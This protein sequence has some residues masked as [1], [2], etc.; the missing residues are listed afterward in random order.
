MA[1][2][3]GA[4]AEARCAREGDSLG[5][6]SARPIDRGRART[7]RSRHA[8]PEVVLQSVSK[9][10][11]AGRRAVDRVSLTIGHGELLVLVG[12]SGC[13]KSS[14][15]RMVAGLEEISEGT[16]AIGGRVVND[17]PPGERDIAMV[18]QNYALYPHMTVFEN[19]AFGLKLRKRP[20]AEV[21]Q[22][23]RETAAV[24]GLEALLDRLPKA[25]SGGERQRVALGRAL[26]RQPQ[27]FLFDEP[28]SNLDAKLRVQTR[29]EIHRLH[30]RLGTTMVYVTHDQ[31]EAMTL[32]QRIAVLKDGVLQQVADPHTLYHRPGNRFVAGFL[33][34]PPMN[35]LEAR[36]DGEGAV[37]LAGASLAARLAAHR[38]RTVTL[39]V[40]PEDLMLTA[41]GGAGGALAAT[42]E[43][44]EPLGNESLLYW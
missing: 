19:M 23:V 24:L 11:A 7:R 16:I 38:G 29:G 14:L 22:R 20:R 32:G 2:V 13:G 25:L 8:M 40:R 35:F 43:V 1:A 28:L 6:R 34:S 5:C 4:G 9:S 26:V 27:V 21:E 30:Q 17:V 10:Y 31:V 33:G 36:V 15:L 12:P 42:L 39:G 3:L 37:T 18:F 41:G 44:R